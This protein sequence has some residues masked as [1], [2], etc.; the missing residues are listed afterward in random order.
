MRIIFTLL[1]ISSLS[2]FSSSQTK[3]TTLYYGLNISKWTNEANRFAKDSGDMINLEE[4]FSNFKFKN[5]SKIG[6]TIGFNMGF[7]ISGNVSFQP[8]IFYSQKGTVFNGEGFFDDVFIEEKFTMITDYVDLPLLFKLTLIPG[9]IKPFI[10]GGP[11][12]G[13]LINSKVKVTVKAMGN[14]ESDTDDLE[15]CKYINLGLVFG[16]G[17]EF[18]DRIRAEIKY[19]SGLSSIFDNDNDDIYIVK[20][21][22][23]SICLAYIINN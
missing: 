10:V 9:K 16:G 18:N 13:Y 1:F 3:T 5:E 21:G 15:N 7:P 14:S 19:D 23:L 11:S 22:V 20:N 4:G 8:G 12:L 17:V 6:F 2:L